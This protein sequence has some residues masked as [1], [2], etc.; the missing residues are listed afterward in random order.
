MADICS[1][2]VLISMAGVWLLSFCSFL[3]ADR[4]PLTA[5]LRR[6]PVN[7]DLVVMCRD[8]TI[9]VLLMYILAS[10]GLGVSVFIRGGLFALCG[11]ASLFAALLC[12][13]GIHSIATCVVPEVGESGTLQP[14]DYDDCSAWLLLRDYILTIILIG[15]PGFTAMIVLTS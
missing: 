14:S 8:L 7:V 5:S 13:V 10:L 2:L 9:L 1:F 12:A 11:S 4:A 6:K 3:L 15:S